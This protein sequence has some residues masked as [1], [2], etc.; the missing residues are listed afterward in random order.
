VNQARGS[1]RVQGFEG[2]SGRRFRVERRC[3]CGGLGVRVR[4]PRGRAIKG[5]GDGKRLHKRVSA[6]R[7]VA[8]TG[9]PHRTE[10]EGASEAQ[11]SGVRRRQVGPTC[12]RERARG[13][14]GPGGP[15]DREGEVA[16]LL[17]LFP[18]F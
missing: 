1:G 6:Q 14:T 15:K 7:A 3:G 13:R 10:R 11:A 16:G 9:R 12:Q 5:R 4:G 17:Y 2:G 18:L 8:L